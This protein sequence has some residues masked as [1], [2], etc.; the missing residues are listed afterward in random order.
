MDIRDRIIQETGW[1]IRESDKAQAA[2]SVRT[3]KIL[4]IAMI[5]AAIFFL[6]SLK[7]RTVLPYI[8]GGATVLLAAGYYGHRTVFSGKL[9]SLLTRDCDPDH[10]L[11]YY[12]AVLLSAGRQKKWES[13][14]YNVV[15]G[16]FYAG[17]FEKAEHLLTLFEEECRSMEGD[18]R[19]DLA[20]AFLAH[21]A[22]DL[23]RLQQYAALLGNES[24]RVRM[25]AELCDELDEAR[26]LPQRHGHRL[27]HADAQLFGRNGR[28]RHNASAVV[29]V[30]GHNRRHK[31]NVRLALLH[32]FGSQPAD[33]GTVDVDMKDDAV[34]SIAKVALFGENCEG[35]LQVERRNVS[36]VTR[37]W[38]ARCRSG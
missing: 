16:L 21:Q 38:R 13:H 5:A 35:V 33:E 22:K 23:P 24:Q 17:E 9:R 26:A 2:A 15:E 25:N 36:A 32:Q 28:C 27:R 31:P 30:T 12:C 18:F 10:F 19:H 8:A 20:G 11:S 34:Q 1:E 6:F 29:R 3:G 7:T 4:R 14:I 37:S